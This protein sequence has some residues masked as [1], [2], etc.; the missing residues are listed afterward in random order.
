VFRSFPSSQNWNLDLIRRYSISAMLAWQ[1]EKMFAG[2]DCVLNVELPG[3]S[4]A[5]RWVV[6]PVVAGTFGLDFL[7]S[8]APWRAVRHL[9]V[10]LLQYRC[11]VYIRHAWVVL[12]QLVERKYLDRSDV[13]HVDRLFADVCR[14]SKGFCGRLFEKTRPLVISTESGPYVGKNPSRC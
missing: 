14:S 12:N 7:G 4:T 3:A 11:R 8:K 5:D 13:S 1:L 9:G 6:F 10:L 2:C